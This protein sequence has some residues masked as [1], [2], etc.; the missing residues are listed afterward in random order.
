MAD[1]LTTTWADLLRDFKGELQEAL[2]HRNLFLQ[3]V[4]KNMNP[5]LWNG[6]QITIPIILSSLQGG[7]FL[8]ENGTLNNPHNIDTDQANIKSTLMAIPVAMSRRLMKA[9]GPTGDQSW[10]EA[11]PKKMEMAEMASDRLLNEAMLGPG[12]SAK[13]SDITGGSS[14]GLTI[15]VGVAANFYQLFPGRIVDI[16]TKAT[17]ADPGQGLARKIASVDRDAGTVTFLTAGFEG[18]SGNITFTTAQGIFV[19]GSFN[20]GPQS[21]VEAAATTG[22]FQGIDK[23]AV[24][25]W[26][27]L[28]ASPSVASDLTMNILDMGELE[29][30]DG[31][32]LEPKWYFGDP[33][34]VRKYVQGLQTQARWNGAERNLKTGQGREFRGVDY[35]GKSLL[36]LHGATPNTVFGWDPS[37]ASLYT[38]DNG[39]E[40]DDMTGSTLQ[41]FN[42]KVTAEAWLVWEIQFGF[43][44]CN[45]IIKIG[46]LNRAT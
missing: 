25:Q 21:I 36:P 26:R 46:S 18:G 32:G 17:G 28:D 9:S 33:F 29:L 15:T 8:S 41:R 31:H 7:G 13:I 12:V 37:I 11:M 42:R 19:Q 35:A 30:L 10:A 27:G 14:P 39:P 3:E 2:A 38:L 34:V 20:Q 24:Q 44:L 40:W 16:L 4:R 23:A 1:E 6:S 22:T 45:S 43:H 5:R